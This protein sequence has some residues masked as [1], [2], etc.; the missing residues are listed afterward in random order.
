[1]KREFIPKE[2]LVFQATSLYRLYDSRVVWSGHAPQAE[3]CGST[4]ACVRKACHFNRYYNLNTLEPP[5]SPAVP[6]AGSHGLQLAGDAL[7]AGGASSY[8]AP[9]PPESSSYYSNS[10][11]SNSSVGATRRRE[12]EQPAAVRGPPPALVTQ[13]SVALRQFH[14]GN[15]TQLSAVAGPPLYLLLPCC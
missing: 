10:S 5:V 7:C 14:N 15:P 2:R 3:A 4:K 8:R 6:R 13:R 11:L 12:T 9:T 1:M